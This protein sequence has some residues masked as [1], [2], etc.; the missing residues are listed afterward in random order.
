METM[1]E[2]VKSAIEAEDEAT[3]LILSFL[4][5]QCILFK[6]AGKMPNMEGEEATYGEWEVGVLFLLALLFLILL[7]CAT[8]VRAS[9]KTHRRY[10]LPFN[11]W[12]PERAINQ[13]YNFIAMS[14]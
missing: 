12:S 10:K 6:I 4:A 9:Q 1:D 13:V 5:H 14:M 8:S 2:W 3:I 11:C 7:I